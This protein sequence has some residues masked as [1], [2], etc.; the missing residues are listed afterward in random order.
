MR[1]LQSLLKTTLQ[2]ELRRLHAELTPPVPE[3]PRTH[4][5]THGSTHPCIRE[6]N[7][8][9]ESDPT[10]EGPKDPDVFCLCWIFP[11]YLRL[12]EVQLDE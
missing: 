5:H 3:D 11:L 8:T 6:L 2:R 1:G 12:S 4:S 10:W 9:Q 7:Y